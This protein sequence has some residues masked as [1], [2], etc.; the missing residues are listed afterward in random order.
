MKSLFR[1]LQRANVRNLI[2]GGLLLVFLMSIGCKNK[3]GDT[4]KVNIVLILADDLGWTDAGF[5]GSGYYQTPAL[6]ALAASGMVFTNA[7]ANAPNCAP[8][9]ASL[10]TGLYTPRHG[11]YTVGNSARGKSEH[12]KLIPVKNKMVLD[13]VFVTIAGVLKSHGYATITLGKWHIGDSSSPLR[14]GFDINI[15]GHQLG[16][17]KSY[18]SPYDNPALEDGPEGE[19]LTERLTEEAIHFI[20]NRKDAPFFMYFPHYTVHTPIQAKDSIIQMYMNRHADERHNNPVYA[21][22]IHSLDESIGK[23]VSELKSQKI[24]E[25][26]IVIFLSD[27]GGHESFTS[28][29]PLKGGKGMLYEGGIRVPFVI[30][31][32]GKVKPGQITEYPVIGTDIFPT[33]IDFLGFKTGIKPDGMSLVPLLV[34]NETLPERPIF[35]HFPA[36]LER[37]PGHPHIWRTTPASVIRSGDWKLIEFFENKDLELYNLK[38]DIGETNNVAE[39]Y[40]DKTRELL[41]ILRD[42]QLETGA[43]VPTEPNPEFNQDS[44]NV[45]LDKIRA[46]IKEN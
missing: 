40:P 26:T 20:R 18:F 41:K 19:F 37:Y 8:S 35:W 32:P 31:W 42:W 33:I 28:Q 2:S 38:T 25:K 10:L 29:L 45:V 14:Q 6:D 13:S 15:G 24:Y 9:R 5:M 1:F 3:N 27:N 44:V 34:Q 22:M 23:L 12:R 43:P 4:T 46:G 21:A 30:S 11:I 7:Y 17:P 36:Y 39:V 16:H